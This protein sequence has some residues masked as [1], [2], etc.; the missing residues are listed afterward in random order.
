MK[1]YLHIIMCVCFVMAGLSDDVFAASDLESRIDLNVIFRI[2]QDYVATPFYL[3][4]AVKWYDENKSPNQLSDTDSHEAAFK[5]FMAAVE[6]KDVEYLVNNISGEISDEERESLATAAIEQIALMSG[7]SVC[8]QLFDGNDRIF[9]CKANAD[10][11]MQG[12]FEYYFG[13][14][15]REE[16][17]HLVWNGFNDSDL[18]GIAKDSFNYS[19][20][21]RDRSEITNTVHSLLPTI[22]GE[23]QGLQPPGYKFDG[24]VCDY[25]LFVDTPKT[26]TPEIV[27]C[28]DIIQNSLVNDDS[29]SAAKNYTDYSQ[30]KYVRWFESMSGES[31]AVYK[32]EQLREVKKIFFVLTAD[33]VYIVFYTDQLQGIGNVKYDTL[34]K[35]KSGDIKLTNLNV[36]GNADNILIDSSEFMMQGIMNIIQKEK[37]K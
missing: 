6:R 2:D 5:K 31:Y 14:G 15:F 13:V 23:T 4:M 35:E 9:M 19:T 16:E 37:L 17:N 34:Y 3:N 10:G 25:I 18:Y 8:C 12:R 7:L 11:L 29:Y 24:Y 28:Y 32:S 33:P 30:Q 21:E 36:F 20:V 22:L 27:K 26:N 1:Y